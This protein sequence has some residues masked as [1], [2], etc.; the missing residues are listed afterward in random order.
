MAVGVPIATGQPVDPVDPSEAPRTTWSVQNW[1]RLE[2]WRFFDPP[3][4]GGNSKY[5]YLA[6]RLRIGIARVSP[7]YEATAALQYVQFGGL[8]SDAVGPG[9]LG[10]GAVYYAH[11]GRRD[12]HQIYL[13]YLNLRVRDVLP[14]VSVQVGR[15]PYAS[16]LE[17]ASGNP[18]IEALKRMRVADRL[19]GEFGW[20][21][22]SHSQMN[23]TDLFVHVLVRPSPPLAVRVDLHRLTLSS[24]RDR[25]YFGSGATQARGTIFGFGTRPSHDAGDLGVSLESSVDYAISPRWSLGGYLGIM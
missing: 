13:R 17:A 5:A 6:N 7:R 25:R 9:P 12:S 8:P 15:M 4:D 3:P 20:S 10:L 23:S 11:A 1:T 19:V 2:M 14:G 21:S 24:S 18:R 16:G 22:A